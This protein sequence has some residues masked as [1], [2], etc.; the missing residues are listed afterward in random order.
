MY[1]KVEDIK[2][3]DIKR[4]VIKDKIAE[5][6]SLWAKEYDNQHSHG[7]KSEEEKNAW[8]RFIKDLVHDK[9]IKVLDV[10]TGTGF[11]GLLCAQIGC[12]VRGIDI[13]EGMLSEARKK[14]RI[15]GY[16]NIFFD[17]CDAENL[18]EV[19][20]KYDMVINRHL[21]WT[22]PN[23]QKAVNEWFRVLK[24]GGK[25]VIIDG[26][27]FYDNKINKIKV[28]LGK[29]LKSIMEG[30]S[31]FNKGSYD[32]ELIEKLPMMKDKNAR[33]I[34]ELLRKNNIYKVETLSL[35]CIEKIEKKQ[36]N[37]I[38]KLLNPYK[39]TVIIAKKPLGWEK[40]HE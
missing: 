6:W 17:M 39:R 35:D 23:P 27:W 9:K 25:L 11:L 34:T 5:N 14:A 37:F 1:Q 40:N 13:S 21:L 32:S 26:D 38:Q 31:A 7:L 29:L 20:N 28:F 30:K 19:S 8:L 3:E 4:D 36:M 18:D 33:N 2:M 24:P 22:L 15:F 10:G 12:E 16:K